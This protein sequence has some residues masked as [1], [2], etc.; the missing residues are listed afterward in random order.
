MRH[1]TTVLAVCTGNIC[2]SPALERLI[3]A[4]MPGVQAVSAGT[5][6]VSGHPMTAEMADL[7]RRAGVDPDGHRAR[8]LTAE[9]VREAT[10]V[11]TMTREHRS[12]VVTLVPSAVRRTF[13]LRELARLTSRIDPRDVPG[14]TVTE[15]VAA[16]TSLAA[17]RRVPHP[18]RPEGDDIDDPFGASP[19]VYAR[20]FGEIERAFD[21]LT[22][23]TDPQPPAP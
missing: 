19:D 20:V 16:L 6:A 4:R 22:A 14:R 23:V 10:L 15:R 7:V 5:H 13:T 21:V 18:D 1:A 11:L 8:Q 2:R 3:A 17:T 12:A 9:A